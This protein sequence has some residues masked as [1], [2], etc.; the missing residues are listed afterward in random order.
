MET[1][2]TFFGR[3]QKLFSTGTII[4]RSDDGLKVADINKVQANPKLATNRMVDRFNRLYQS[5]QNTGYNQEANFHT[6]RIQLYTD[7]E[8]MDEDSII[9][10]ALD[11]YADESTLKNELGDVL[12]IQSDNEEIEKVLN[13]LFYDILNIEFNAWPWVRNM[14]K[15]GDFYLKLDITEKVGITNVTP[16]SSYE[17]FR[18]DGTDPNNPE[19][20]KFTHDESMG[21][22]GNTKA[23]SELDN[24]EVAHFRLLN[25]MNFLPYGKSMIEPARKTWKQLTLME[26]AMMIHRIMRA[27]EKRIYK[28]DIGNIP[29]N[30]VDAYMQR[31]MQSMKKTPYID[32]KTGNYNLKFN[33]QN[34]MEDV[35]LPVRG[36]QSGTE[37]ES[38][39]GMDFGGIDDI[40]YLKN[41]MFAALKIPKAFMGYEEDLNAKSTLAAQDI[42]FARTIER[43]QRIFVSE[44]TK[45]AMVHLYSQGF[46]DQDMLDFD[47]ELA[48]ASTIAEQEKMELWA[49]KVDLASSIKDLG[50]MSEEWIY[51]NLFELNEDD[52]EKMKTGVIEDTKQKFRRASIEGEGVDPAAEQKQ[53]MPTEEGVGK[54]GKVERKSK[55]LSRNERKEIYKSLFKTKKV[56]NN[57]LL[58]ENNILDED[59]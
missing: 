1:D 17:M 18:E 36:G 21:G 38:L 40:E 46:E 4:R 3:L 44:L 54:L 48:P 58:S 12:K 8:I 20:V 34:M 15:Y 42:R 14:C 41:R 16:M 55:N 9:S 27:P 47:L 5:S 52:V 23:A 56:N 30:E 29:P 53:S 11:I 45:I 2:K 50:M 31:V 43:I 25:D 10:A 51:E 13:N 57:N 7:Y 59:I 26:D 32:S 6:M 35:Y 22:I 39:S 37:I 33:M 28:I 49:T 19:L 24:Y